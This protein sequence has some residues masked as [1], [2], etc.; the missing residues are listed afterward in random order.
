MIYVGIDVAKDKHD[1]C[2]LGTE[3][4]T[5]LDNL[6]I[7]NNLSGFELLE[8]K[9]KACEKDIE[10]IKLGLEATGHYSKNLLHFLLKK[11]F[12]VYMLNPLTVNLYRRGQTIRKTKTDR[13]DAKCI[14]SYVRSDVNLRPYTL[15]SYHILELKSLC[16]YRLSRI[17]DVNKKKVELRR[18]ITILFPELER[19]VSSVHG[20][21]IYTLLE[22]FPDAAQIAKTNL[23]RLSNL[24]GTASHGRHGKDMAMRIRE[25]ARSS[26]GTI[27]KA[28]SME[29]QN[30]IRHIRAYNLEIAEI[31]EEINQIMTE[32][33]SPIVSIPGLGGVMGAMILAEVGDFSNFRSADQLLAFA[34]LAPSTY[35]S[36][37]YQGTHGRMEKR[38]SSYLRYAMHHASAA[39]CRFDPWF[40]AYFGKKRL[41]G[42]HYYVALSHVARKLINLMFIMAKHNEPYHSRTVP[43]SSKNS[44]D[45]Q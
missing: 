8:S 23:T 6:T 43:N 38:G 17:N 4:E 45:F 1:C 32:V 28:T 19:L 44:L 12:T 10:Q 25:A 21:A 33:D 20:N 30:T 42:K 27:S 5:L 9:L 22:A 18:L 24:L 39:V 13:I 7:T 2:I 41:E 16:R 15:I 26:I 14:A 29:L 37:Q 35:Q 11:G 34:G 36:G 40:A 3:G 31:E